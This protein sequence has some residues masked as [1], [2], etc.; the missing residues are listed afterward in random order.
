MLWKIICPGKESRS[1]SIVSRCTLIFRSGHKLFSELK[2]IL[3]YPSL[4]LWIPMWYHD[5]KSDLPQICVVDK[6]ITED[7]ADAPFI[8]ISKCHYL[9][10]SVRNKINIV[11]SLLA[12]KNVYK[13]VLNMI[14]KVFEIR[15]GPITSV[16]CFN[17]IPTL[18]EN[19]KKDVQLM[20]RFQCCVIHEKRKRRG[21]CFMNRNYR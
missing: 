18:F 5:R 21:G 10:V 13:I 3:L 8:C 9:F 20:W 1:R 14:W 16:T 11:K 19:L 6:A 7:D 4:V 15:R 2:E 12:D 17:L